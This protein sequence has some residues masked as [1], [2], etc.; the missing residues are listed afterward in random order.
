M[1]ATRNVAAARAPILAGGYEKTT[2]PLEEIRWADLFGTAP[3]KTG[4]EVTLKI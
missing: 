2:V 3:L 4:H 1:R